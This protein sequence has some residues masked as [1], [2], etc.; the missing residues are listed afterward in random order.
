[1]SGVGLGSAALVSSEALGSAQRWDTWRG[2]EGTLEMP[3]LDQAL[4]AGCLAFHKPAYWVDIDDGPENDSR[5]VTRL[6][7]ADGDLHAAQISLCTHPPSLG[8]CRSL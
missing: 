4:S 7:D 3:A 6:F 1:M 5:E 8:A 2:K